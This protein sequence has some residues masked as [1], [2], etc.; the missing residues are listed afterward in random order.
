MQFSMFTPLLVHVSFC[1]VLLD[2]PLCSHEQRGESLVSTDFM[3]ISLCL[4][5]LSLFPSLFHLVACL[6]KE[7][8][9]EINGSFSREKVVCLLL[10]TSH[11]LHMSFIFLIVHSMKVILRD[12]CPPNCVCIFL[13]SL[14][15]CASS[16]V[17][18]HACYG[19]FL[20]ESLSTSGCYLYVSY[21]T[22]RLQL[23]LSISYCNAMCVSSR[24]RVSCS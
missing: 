19:C 2:S 18:L 4:H 3:L 14:C 1:Y 10:S 13:C 6:L 7:G 22:F 8:H 24:E 12:A 11:Y 5:T 9:N 20:P 15:L 21:Q 23:Q 17:F 16:H